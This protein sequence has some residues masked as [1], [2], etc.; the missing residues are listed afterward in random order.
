ME[1]KNYNCI[2]NIKIEKTNYGFNKYLSSTISNNTDK[3]RKKI[4]PKKNPGRMP[5]RKPI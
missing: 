3:R 5:T 4:I 1:K 2:N